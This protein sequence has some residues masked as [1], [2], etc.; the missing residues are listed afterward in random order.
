MTRVLITLL[1]AVSFSSIGFSQIN[2]NSSL[3]WEVTGNSLKQPSYLFGTTHVICK[4]H[5]FFPDIV[6]EKFLSA[7]EVFLEQDLADSSVNEK[8]TNAF[9]KTS[10]K[11][12]QQLLGEDRFKQFDSVFMKITGE[13]AKQY[14]NYRPLYLIGILNDHTMICGETNSYEQWF[15]DLAAMYKKKIMGLETIEESVTV[16]DA[17]PDSIFCTALY[18]FAMNFQQ[19]IN[20]SQLQE[21][22][23]KTQDVEVIFQQV[24]EGMG[25]FGK[26]F[27][28]VHK[29]RNQ[30]WIP[31]MQKSML[32]GPSFFAVGVGHLGGDIGVIA[33]LRKEGY[34][35][36][37]VKL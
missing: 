36:K 7:N 37:P 15:I 14:N 5:F 19:Q 1:F 8:L 20:N 11:T 3:L 12:I 29:R 23:Y 4:E 10:G 22:L 34:T 27:L 2:L 30:N 26:E 21:S 6:K 28:S 31:I 18:E 17:I 33:L 9:Q 32:K 35:V 25:V 13:Q 24:V 16:F